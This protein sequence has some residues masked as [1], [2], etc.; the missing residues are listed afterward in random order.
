M[1]HPMKNRKNRMR[2]GFT[3]VEVL[4]ATAVTLLMMISLANIFKIIG[5]SMQEGRAT[6]ELNNRLRNVALRVQHDLRNLVLDEQVG[7]VEYTDG[8][9]TDATAALARRTD[10]SRLVGGNRF[11]DL[12]DV[13]MFTSKAED[14]WFTGKVPR[15]M[16]TGFDLTGA[17]V[18][19]SNFEMVT[20][21]SEYAE[22]AVFA[23]PV[24]SNAGGNSTF[25]PSAMVLNPAAFLDIDNNFFPDD[26]NLHYRVLLI[27]PDLNSV[28]GAG[29]VGRRLPLAI[30]PGKSEP[31]GI[32]QPVFAIPPGGVNADIVAL[33]TPLC[34]M[35]RIHG[36]CDLSVRRIQRSAVADGL[37][38]NQDYVAANDLQTLKDPAN[39]FAHVQIPIAGGQTLPLLALAQRVGVPGAAGLQPFFDFNGDG[40][41]DM[42]EPTGIV[43]TGA[44][45]SFV[46]TGF[47]HPAFT[48]HS[49]WDAAL[50][51]ASVT[52]P[53]HQISASRVGEDI[54]ANNIRAFD[55][56]CFDPGVPVL[57]S[58]GESLD[59][60]DSFPDNP[61]VSN[62]SDDEILLPSD[63]G[64]IAAV[65]R[66]VNTATAATVATVAHGGYV[67][68]GWARKLAVVAPSFGVSLGGAS[69]DFPAVPNLWSAFSGYDVR[70]WTSGPTFTDEMY[71]SGKVIHLP[72]TTPMVMQF[73]A[74]TSNYDHLE[75]NDV[76]EAQ[77]Q[78]TNGNR[79]GVIQVAES[80]TF[81]LIPQ[82]HVTAPWIF[83]SWRLK[84]TGLIRDAST[85]GLDNDGRGF[86]DD[87]LE[88]ESTSPF[89]QKLTGIRLSIRMEDPATRIVKQQSVGQHIPEH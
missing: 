29:S 43:P 1:T 27:R 54:L 7:Y 42:A 85:D 21:A 32:A 36:Q 22:I 25:D 10:G 61:V 33:P 12:D 70:G 56:K 28:I 73:T 83:D 39:R 57:V 20:I 40:T 4:V 48:M 26:Y 9:Q 18:D 89:A 2:S 11:G 45:A 15:Y 80:N 87:R 76:L 47:L 78:T 64:Y 72:S 82:I 71:R 62:T 60:A 66:S 86:A 68:L 65:H 77:L 8:A 13:L 63:P 37:V 24:V 84:A 30:H 19:E 69:G 35:A 14:V 67:D 23:Q 38:A 75:T 79:L 81:P 5:D 58:Y 34:D 50:D 52:M 74:D 6:L 55:V 17:G 88:R 3:L 16:L 46:G 44:G 49:A 53:A 31:W 41:D 51:D 59:P